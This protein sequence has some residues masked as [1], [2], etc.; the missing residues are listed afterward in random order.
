MPLT[1]ENKA[2][3]LTSVAKRVRTVENEY[4]RL[5]RALRELLSSLEQP[6]LPGNQPAFEQ[7]YQTVLGPDADSLSAADR[8]EVIETVFTEVLG[9]IDHFRE[10]IKLAEAQ[11]FLVGEQIYALASAV[12]TT[13]ARARQEPR[14]E[15]VRTTDSSGVLVF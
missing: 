13:P 5:D 7:L 9:V 11:S 12:S 3:S 4:H 10:R 1:N 2:Q 15:V 6:L 14:L 8:W